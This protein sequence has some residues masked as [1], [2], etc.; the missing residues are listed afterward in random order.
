M[1]EA[2]RLFEQRKVASQGVHFLLVRPDDSGVTYTGL[3][4][5]RG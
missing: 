2:G 1:A 3:W 5:L 4:L